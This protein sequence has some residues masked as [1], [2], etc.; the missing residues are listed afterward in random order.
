LRMHS[1]SFTGSSAAW[2]DVSDVSMDAGKGPASEA[3]NKCQSGFPRIRR[4]GP[5]CKS[6]MC[7]LIT[8]TR[9]LSVIVAV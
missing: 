1:K 8:T 6:K 2:I 5:D 7:V 3:G 9:M 4:R